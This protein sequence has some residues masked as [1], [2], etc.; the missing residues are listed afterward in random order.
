VDITFWGKYILKMFFVPMLF[1]V[2]VCIVLFQRRRTILSANTFK[3]RCKASWDIAHKF[4]PTFITLCCALYTF[5]ASSAID[6]LNCVRMDY[7]ASAPVYAIVSAPSFRC[8]DE[9]WYKYLPVVILFCF[10]YGVS[11]P[12]VVGYI[13]FTNRN[14]LYSRQFMKGYGSLYRSLRHSLYFWELVIMLKK[15]SFVLV[16]RVLS[17]RKNSSYG[18]RFASAISI[19]GFFFAIEALVQPYSRQSTNFRSST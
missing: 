12:F 11:F 19:V 2:L 13:L 14:N 6:P 1:V 9:T 4:I 3:E 18:E 15:A 7:Q 5:V 10:L 8:Y 17:S 16:V